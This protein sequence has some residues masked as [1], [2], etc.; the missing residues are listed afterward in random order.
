MNSTS[1]SFMS[2]RSVKSSVSFKRK[3]K[4]PKIPTDPKRPN[5]GSIQQPPKAQNSKNRVRIRRSSSGLKLAPM[6]KSS[7]RKASIVS[8]NGKQDSK[9]EEITKGLLFSYNK[10]PKIPPKKN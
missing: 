1:N 9:D 7:S 4:L 6:R 5:T 2:L 10:T 3:K 8:S